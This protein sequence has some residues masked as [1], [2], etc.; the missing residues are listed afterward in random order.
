MRFSNIKTMTRLTQKKKM[1][2]RRGNIQ[3]EVRLFA[4]PGQQAF[5]TMQSVTKGVV[6]LRTG[7][8]YRV[9]RP[10]LSLIA[11]S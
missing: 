5:H 4:G 9:A 1:K 7:S 2:R 8:T 10:P 3:K 11:Q 6:T